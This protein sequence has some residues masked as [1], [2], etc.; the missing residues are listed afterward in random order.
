MAVPLGDTLT[1][2]ARRYPRGLS[3][4]RLRSHLAGSRRVF[5]ADCLHLHP[6]LLRHCFGARAAAYALV[7]LQI[8]ACLSALYLVARR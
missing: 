7:G 5:Q 6:R 1:A 8:L 2:I 4:T 3:L